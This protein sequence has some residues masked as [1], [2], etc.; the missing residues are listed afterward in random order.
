MV[1]HAG[2]FLIRTQNRT[3]QRE[4]R[5]DIN[6]HIAEEP[7]PGIPGFGVRRQRISL[8]REL[9]DPASV[10]RRNRGK[11]LKRGRQFK[12]RQRFAV[13]KNAEF[14]LLQALFQHDLRQIGKLPEYH[15]PEI[16]YAFPDNDLLDSCILPKRT[17]LV[18]RVIIG[19]AVAFKI[20]CAEAVK[21]PGNIQSAF[22]AF[23]DFRVLFVFN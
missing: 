5:G 3:V 10:K 21:I 12:L 22:S 9:F 14:H 16:G 23:N 7:V 18:S 11:P 15:A 19:P 13:R 4:G 17:R 20:K 8:E 2:S 1:E 6:F